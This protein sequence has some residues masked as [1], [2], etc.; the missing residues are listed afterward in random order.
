MLQNATDVSLTGLFHSIVKAKNFKSE[1]HDRRAALVV[2]KA[3]PTCRNLVHLKIVLV[4]FCSQ[5]FAK[6]RQILQLI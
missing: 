5:T 4:L 2:V 3:K 1:G 6:P